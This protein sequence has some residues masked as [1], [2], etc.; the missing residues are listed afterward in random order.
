MPENKLCALCDSAVRPF[1]RN[2][3]FGVQRLIAALISIISHREKWGCPNKAG[4]KIAPMHP[5]YHTGVDDDLIYDNL[6]I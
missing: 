1:S 6:K 2:V 3:R 5:V 4:K